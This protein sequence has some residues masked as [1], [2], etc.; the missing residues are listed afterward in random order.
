MTTRTIQMPSIPS[1]HQPE[2]NSTGPTQITPDQDYYWMNPTHYTPTPDR[3]MISQMVPTMSI[4]ELHLP[5]TKLEIHIL[6]TL[7][8]DH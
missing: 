3:S 8:Q 6:V 4:L 1:Q 5:K 2:T 7:D